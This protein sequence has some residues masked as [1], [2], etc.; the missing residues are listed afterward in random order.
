MNKLIYK[1]SV[2]I[3]WAILEL[4]S[5]VV[6]I[7]MNTKKVANDPKGILIDDNF[8]SSLAQTEFYETIE[9]IALGFIIFFGAGLLHYGIALLKTQRSSFKGNDKFLLLGA[10]GLPLAGIAL[11]ILPE[12]LT[13]PD[14]LN[15][16]PTVQTEQLQEKN[17]TLSRWGDKYCFYFSSG[18]SE[19][20]RKDEYLNTP[21]GASFYIIYQGK[22]LIKIYPADKYTYKKA[23]QI[24]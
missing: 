21:I 11:I 9:F 4:I 15:Y 23:S 24:F 3:I 10:I 5:A 14:R 17:T 16:S 12:S 7:V 19:K 22:T 2:F 1:K 6:A 8:L 18:N 20:V 13:L